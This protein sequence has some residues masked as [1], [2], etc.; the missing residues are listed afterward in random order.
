MTLKDFSFPVGFAI[1]HD[2]FNASYLAKFDTDARSIT[3]ENEMK[4]EGLQPREGE[5]HYEDSDYVV[6]F[7]EAR[8]LRVH[9]HTL[10]WAHNNATPAWVNA[11]EGTV[12]AREKAIQILTDHITEVVSHYAGR[13]ASWDVVNEAFNASGNWADCF[14]LRVIGPDY[15]KLAFQAAAA[16]DPTCKLF[17]NGYGQETGNTAMYD[18]I[19]EQKAIMDAA[20]IP[21]HGVG[22]Q[23]HTLLDATIKDI[24]FRTD[25]IRDRFRLYAKEGFLIHLSE[26]DVETKQRS[27]TYTPQLEKDLAT[28]YRDIFDA[29]QTVIPEP[30][31]WG[32]TMWSVSDRDNYMNRSGVLQFPML[33]DKDYNAKQAYYE[34]LNLLDPVPNTALIYQSFEEKDL[35]PS[36]I[37]IGSPTKGTAPAN[38]TMV[39]SDSNAKA[40]VTE[41]G[42]S[43]AQTQTNLFNHIIVDSTISNY[44]LSTKTGEV[45]YLP[46]R[47][48]HLAFRF[49]DGANLFSVQAYKSATEDVWRLVKRENGIDMVLHTSTVT[50]VWGQIV[51]VTCDGD[52][53]SYSIDGQVQA[54]IVDSSFQTATKLGFKMKGTY[55]A[56]KFSSW[57]FIKVDPIPQIADDFAFGPTGN[58]NGRTTNSGTV[59]KSWAVNGSSAVYN[60]MEVISEGLR[61]T[62]GTA[63][64]YSNALIDS[65]VSNYKLSAT[66][67]KTKPENTLERNAIMLFRVKDNSN[68]YYLM[69]NN[70]NTTDKKWVLTKRLNGVNTVMITSPFDAKDGDRV[71][72]V[73]NGNVIK[74]YV[75]DIF[76]DSITDG[77]F[78]TEKKIGFR[79]RGQLDNY[80]TWSDIQLKY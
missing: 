42:L 29:Y 48:M 61:A 73:A 53:I 18:K 19:M 31:R 49:V 72:I 54:R 1:K 38:W 58:A 40:E 12:G 7:A 10:I 74:L 78:A 67:A 68:F 52:K 15:I 35:I 9:G 30:Q 41:T 55:N 77:T 21:F 26:L 6:N 17:Y 2:Y 22:F 57:K 3:G 5:F 20:N 45:Y 79:G 33:F 66:L 65:G 8:N 56:D 60:G 71:T 28:F 80:S 4:F 46:Q 36:N 24:G 39:S 23:M 13:I 64:S 50:P 51:S 32:I 14:W 75:N 59:L 63:T 70:T 43:M 11:Y 27:A 16:A 62:S 76:I 69:V 25:R 47:V 44:T 34:V 37:F